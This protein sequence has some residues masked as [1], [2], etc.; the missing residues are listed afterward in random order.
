MTTNTLTFN[1]N[2]AQAYNHSPYYTLPR[3]CLYVGHCAVCRRRVYRFADGDDDPRGPLGE[4]AASVLV[5]EDSGM[6]GP[7]IKLCFGCADD[8]G[9][10]LKAIGAAGWKIS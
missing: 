9:C 4:H 2:A 5:A 10:C 1:R 8:Q 3:E 6:T 7:D